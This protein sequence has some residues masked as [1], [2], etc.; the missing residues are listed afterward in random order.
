MFYTI[1]SHVVF[2]LNNNHLFINAMYEY[3]I[4]FMRLKSLNK[5]RMKGR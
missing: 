2:Y 1:L 3:H 5:Y 4:W